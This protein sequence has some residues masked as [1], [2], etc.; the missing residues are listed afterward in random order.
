M[1]IACLAILETRAAVANVFGKSSSFSFPSDVPNDREPNAEKLT[2]QIGRLF[3][4]TTYIEW[5]FFPTGEQWRWIQDLQ[6]ELMLPAGLEA[7]ICMLQNKM[8]Y[9]T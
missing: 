7:Q 5:I 4:R 6:D 9:S 8:R 2:C 1:I 3:D